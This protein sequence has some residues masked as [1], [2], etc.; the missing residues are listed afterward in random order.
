MTDIDAIFAASEAWL[1]DPAHAG[2]VERLEQL[3]AE[4]PATRCAHQ[5]L[6]CDT[7]LWSAL[8][9]HR[10]M[11]WLADTLPPE[12]R[13]AFVERLL[14]HE[15]RRR[16]RPDGSLAWRCAFHDDEQARCTIYPAR[17]L[18]CRAYGVLPGTCSRVELTADSA[19]APER[20]AALVAELEGMTERIPTDPPIPLMLPVEI[21]V[22]AARD[23]L[24]EAMTWYLGSPFHTQLLQ[25]AESPAP[26]PGDG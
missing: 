12:S 21:W 24:K 15:P 9:Y 13:R 3:E 7:S 19:L 18:V 4:L 23:G 16:D 22:R 11:R 25:L 6:C 17:A 2:W 1:D 5:G 20:F 8:E 14:D 26:G 10:A